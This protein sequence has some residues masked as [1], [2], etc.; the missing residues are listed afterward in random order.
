ML[1]LVPKVEV[2][3]RANPHAAGCPSLSHLG[4]MIVPAVAAKSQPGDER[5]LL[6]AQQTV[7]LR[8]SRLRAR[9]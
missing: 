9:A 5:R 2:V 8:R 7:G 1:D 3:Y 6:A 4:N